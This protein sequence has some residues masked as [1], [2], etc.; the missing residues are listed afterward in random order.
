MN[1]N[2]TNTQSLFMSWFPSF[3]ETFC[4]HFEKYART[5]VL[6]ADF[7]TNMVKYRRVGRSVNEPSS[8][9]FC[10]F[11]F[12]FLL[13]FA[14]LKIELHLRISLRAS[15]SPMSN[16]GNYS[17]N[18]NHINTDNDNNNFIYNRTLL[19]NHIVQSQLHLSTFH[20]A[21]F[22]CVVCDEA[23]HPH[24]LLLADTMSTILWRRKQ[25]REWGLVN[26]VLPL[27]LTVWNISLA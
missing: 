13:S 24:L 21:F 19:Y 25:A 5:S 8:T 18:S 6:P 3:L 9:I 12:F 17:N 7:R 2:P 11:F 4:P 14:F 26:S 15:P 1:D 27:V 23:E 10:L 16:K 22:N 20:N